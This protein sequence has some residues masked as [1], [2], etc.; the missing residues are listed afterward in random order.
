MKRVKNRCKAST[1]MIVCTAIVFILTVTGIYSASDSI[2]GFKRLGDVTTEMSKTRRVLKDY[3]TEML[4]QRNNVLRYAVTLDKYYHDLWFD[5]IKRGTRESLADEL[6]SLKLTEQERKNFEEILSMQSKA[7]GV[8]KE[9]LGVEDRKRSGDNSEA[10]IPTDEKEFYELTRYI[11]RLISATEYRDGIDKINKMYDELQQSIIDRS[12]QAR[13]ANQAKLELSLKIDVAMLCGIFLMMFILYLIISGRVLRPLEILEKHFTKMTE[14]DL[15]TRIALEEDTSEVGQLVVSA[16]SMQDILT[17]ITKEID[18]VLYGLSQGNLKQK[19][20]RDFVG[21]FIKIRESL[22]QIITSY[23]ESFAEINNAAYEVSN[24]S[25]QIAMNSQSLSQGAT[26]QASTIEE[27]TT[28]VNEITARIGETLE[29]AENV[30]DATV[31]MTDVIKAGNESMLKLT[32]TMKELNNNSA[33]ISKIVK[34]IDNIAF[35]TN[36]LA[37]N[38]SVEAARAE[39]YGASFAVVADE[40]RALAAQSAQSAQATAALI[41]NTISTIKSGVDTAGDAENMLGAMIDKAD[42]VKSRVVK[43]T[44]A[45]ESD[46]QAMQM[47]L[48]SLEQLS[49]VVQSNSANAEE[50]AAA[51]EEI[52]AQATAVVELVKKFS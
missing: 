26:E 11:S 17:G 38:A 23:G 39:Q 52:A 9:A 51:S 29:N 44:Q 43:I 40:V 12:T 15:H 7:L 41:E 24:G 18:N 50:T 46:S 13:K 1:M 30:K 21:D 22:E 28:T 14:G 2:R 8:Q 48:T 49:A 33:E 37:L 45:M 10:N 47:A 6:K 3:Q 42:D 27:L 20:E 36:I 31:D 16:N 19:I 4:D 5:R 34:T 35:Q 32:S 25:E